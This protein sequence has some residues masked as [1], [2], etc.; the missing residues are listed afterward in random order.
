METF[1]YENSEFSRSNFGESS[2]QQF[3]QF[4]EKYFSY[5]K[6]NVVSQETPTAILTVGAHDSGKDVIVAQA[7]DELNKKGGS[8][9]IDDSIFKVADPQQNKD[10]S[11]HQM[12]SGV[13][14]EK[15][16]LLLN[17]EFKDEKVL[18]DITESL[19]AKNYTVEVRAV[20]SIST[21]DNSLGNN[22]HSE[23]VRTI[24]ELEDSKSVDSFKVYDRVG[25]EVYSNT[26]NDEGVWNQKK[27][28]LNIY[29][30]ETN[31]PLSKT[32]AEYNLLTQQQLKEIENSHI[33]INPRENQ[34]KN[35]N[36]KSEK[37]LEI[38]LETPKIIKDPGS[39]RDIVHGIVTDESD[40]E[41]TLK[42]NNL[43]GIKYS[44]DQFKEQLEKDNALYR[45]RELFINH[46]GDVPQL[47]NEK[48]I[49]DF[50]ITQEQT[51]QHDAGV[52]L[53]R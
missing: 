47:M 24:E 36:E 37:N 16:N 27:A 31:K 43:V 7:Q 42:I 26:R 52:E 14:E 20:S 23:T 12:I 10:Q 39:F 40:K 8:I 38:N 44:K 45:G 48:E 13:S 2:T 46:A 34:N 4:I 25:K 35:I 3:S 17:H 1:K 19:K 5:S 21:I 28:G 49:Q 51:L 29:N 9:L 30:Q 6:A 15:Y 22:T 11:I 18:N 32:E 33:S 41:F 53:D 50:H